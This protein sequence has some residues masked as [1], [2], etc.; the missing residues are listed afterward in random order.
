[1]FDPASAQH[2]DFEKNF[3]ASPFPGFQ[4]WEKSEEKFGK[5]RKFEK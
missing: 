3:V 2:V 5:K 1:M 4:V